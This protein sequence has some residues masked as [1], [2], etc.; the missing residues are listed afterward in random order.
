MTYRDDELKRDIDEIKNDIFILKTNVVSIVKHLRLKVDDTLNI[1][2]IN[3]DIQESTVNK[4]SIDV[5]DS[6]KTEE[7]ELEKFFQSSLESTGIIAISQ[8]T[9]TQKNEISLEDIELSEEVI[10]KPKSQEL[11]AE[12]N[13][14]LLI[15]FSFIDKEQ[16]KRI[17]DSYSKKLKAYK[18]KDNFLK[19]CDAAISLIED[20]VKRFIKRKFREL[21]AEKN[22]QLIEGYALLEN[23]WREKRFTLDSIYARKNDVLYRQK[24]FPDEDEKYYFDADKGEYLALVLLEKSKMSFLTELCFAVMYGS[25][26]YK[27]KNRLSQFRKSV[28]SQTSSAAFQRPVLKSGVN[29]QTVKLKHYYDKLYSAKQFR[30]IYEHNK[31]NKQKQYEEIEN[32]KPYVKADLNKYNEIAE[33]VQWFVYQLYSFE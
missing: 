2:N 10:Q 16:A 29:S 12:D 3:I 14:K 18:E 33:A 26:F 5:Q 1:E 19:F 25:E 11:V 6:S 27:Q 32:Q 13:E 23:D 22:R 21:V 28:Q 8:E 30:N 7:A 24:D 17:A 31:N 20:F 4:I 9:L 15:D